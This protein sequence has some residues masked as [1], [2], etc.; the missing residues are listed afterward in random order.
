MKPKFKSLLSLL[1]SCM[2][3][4]SAV[5]KNLLQVLAEETVDDEAVEEIAEDQTETAITDETETETETGDEELA[6]TTEEEP[7]FQEIDNSEVIPEIE[8]SEPESETEETG[9]PKMYVVEVL[10]KS[11]LHVVETST[12]LFGA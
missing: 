11:K 5:D 6:E 7:E 4:L 2:M 9:T 1:L 10:K 12:F 8:E 3:C